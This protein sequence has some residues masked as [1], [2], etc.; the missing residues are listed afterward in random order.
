MKTGTEEGKK[1]TDAAKGRLYLIK[2]R[3]ASDAEE[4]GDVLTSNAPKVE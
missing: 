2:L 3:T 4:L 1:E